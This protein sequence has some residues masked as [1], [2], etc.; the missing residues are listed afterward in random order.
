MTGKKAEPY[1][2]LLPAVTLALIFSILPF[3]RSIVLSFLRV[4]QNGRIIGFAALDN[5]RNLFSDKAF[6]QSISHTLLFVALF[7]PLNT[8]LTLAAAAITRRKTRRSGLAEF[9]FFSPLAVSLSAYS[10]IFSEMFRGRISIINRILSMDMLWL[11]S[12]ESAMAVLVML[13]VFLDFGLDYILLLSSFRSIDKSV[14]EAAEIDGC[15]GIRTLFMI[16]L[17]QIR[18]MLLITVFMALKDALL[19]S[20]PVMLLTEGGPFRSTE[21][22]MYYYYL[23]AFRSSNLQKGRTI[24]TLMAGVSMILVALAS[25]RRY[26]E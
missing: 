15:S 12:P 3:S 9:I 26:H 17:P 21:T 22:V 14:I 2:L 1:I 16:E 7:L 13:S 23:E 19:I 8:A 18:P 24:S 10:M 4:T 5:Y 6:V 11:E 25:R 20:A